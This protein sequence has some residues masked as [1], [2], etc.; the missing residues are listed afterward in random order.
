MVTNREKTNTI[1]RHTGSDRAFFALTGIVLTV[2]VILVSYPIIYVLSASFSSAK[3]VTSGRV[4]LWPVEFSLEGYRAVFKH[5]K[6]IPAF[7]NTVM[8]TT[9]G[10]VINVALAMLCAYPLSRKDLK[11]RGFFTVLFTFTMFFSG[12][13]IPSYLQVLRLGLIDTIGALVLPG[14][15]SVYHMLVMRTFIANSIPAD[16]FEAAAIDGCSDWRY[17]LQIVVPLSMAVIAV[18]GMFSAVGHWNS[19]FSAMIY[20][21]TASKYPLQ[22]ILREILIMNQIDLSMIMEFQQKEAMTNLADVL[23]YSL[24]VVATAPILMVYPFVQKYFVKG[25]MIGSIKG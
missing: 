6:I 25:V 17:L 5:P 16:L 14:A 8:Y 22:I 15:L 23:K 1:T 3:A 7:L 2:L 4:L 18:V 20:L 24:I 19:Y 9:L 21:N 13:L 10:T 11:G 12:G